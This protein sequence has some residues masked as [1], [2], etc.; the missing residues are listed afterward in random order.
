MTVNCVIMILPAA[1]VGG[2]LA[3][4]LG[5]SL[6]TALEIFDVIL[7]CACRRRSESAAAKQNRNRKSPPSATGKGNASNHVMFR[8]VAS[9]SV[10]DD[11]DTHCSTNHRA[12]NMTPVIMTP[13]GHA[14][15]P[16]VKVNS[17]TFRGSGSRQAE[18]D[19]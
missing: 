6:I 15:L 13:V 18:T 12:S 8:P 10:D 3:L 17:M 19:I 4:F 5:A 7:R 14:T 11:D 9:E 1:H 16:K 2:L